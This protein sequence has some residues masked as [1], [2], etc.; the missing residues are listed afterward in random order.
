MQVQTLESVAEWLTHVVLDLQTEVVVDC[1]PDE[2]ADMALLRTQLSVLR[3]VR[4]ASTEAAQKASVSVNGLALTSTAMDVLRGSLPEWGGTLRL[5]DCTYPLPPSAY[6]QLAQSA[7]VSYQT[8]CLGKA[9]KAQVLE[10]ICA[11]LNERRAGLGLPPVTVKSEA[12]RSAERAIGEH[13]VLTV[14]FPQF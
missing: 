14:G 7:P 4:L 5:R 10:S 9:A 3:S 8:W 12:H 2:T 13:V 6:T 1:L 11:G